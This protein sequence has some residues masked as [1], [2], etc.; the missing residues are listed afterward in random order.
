M[1]GVPDSAVEVAGRILNALEYFQ[2]IVTRHC[3]ATM[4]WRNMKGKCDAFKL[5]ERIP[6]LSAPIRKERHNE[7]TAE[8]A[9]PGFRPDRSVHVHVHVH[10][11]VYVHIHMHIHD[12]T[13]SA[14]CLKYGT[15]CVLS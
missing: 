1:T 6:L 8:H 9:S 11:Y 7:P 15:Y 5:E 12:P 13:R 10:V 3:T 2:D 14:P 4:T